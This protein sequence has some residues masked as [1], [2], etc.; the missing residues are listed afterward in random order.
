[1]A[2][3]NC[4]ECNK[5]ISDKV[6]ACPHCGYPVSGSPQQ[7]ELT[8][9]KL[10]KPKVNKAIITGFIVIIISV[11]TFFTFN[12]F[13]KQAE[14]IA[15]IENLNVAISTMLDGAGKAEELAGLTHKVWSN[16]IFKK[17]DP[18]TNQYTIDKVLYDKNK[19]YY[20]NFAFNDFNMSLRNLSRD[21]SV[22]SKIKNINEIQDTVAELLKSLQSPPQDLQ[23]CFVELDNLY[24]VFFSF[25]ELAINPSGNLTSFASKY[26]EYDNSFLEH[27]NKI[28]LLIPEQ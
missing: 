21:S 6:S 14:R 5:E 25:T 28:K 17:S 8:A 13:K 12:Y 11:V 26:N 15:Y 10:S 4:P 9:I 7:V 16:A 20:S 3:I 23:N 27:Y 18:S 22:I 1:M 19:T 2:L 24:N